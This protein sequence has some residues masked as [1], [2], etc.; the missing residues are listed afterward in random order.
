MAPRH[1]QPP[2]R[3]QAPR[4]SGAWAGLAPRSQGYMPSLILSLCLDQ[5]PPERETQGEGPALNGLP[6]L[7]WH[8]VPGGGG[9]LWEEGRGQS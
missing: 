1:G 8:R 4:G 2:R 3:A 9:R 7:V 5:D 6:E